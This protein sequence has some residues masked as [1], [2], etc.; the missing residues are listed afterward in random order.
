MSSRELFSND[1][2]PIAAQLFCT[3]IA[4]QV[5]HSGLGRFEFALTGKFLSVPPSLG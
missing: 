3:C 5:P 1:D 2:P 4:S